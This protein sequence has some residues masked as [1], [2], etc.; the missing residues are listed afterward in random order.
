MKYTDEILI[1]KGNEYKQFAYGNLE[2]GMYIQGVFYEFSRQKLTLEDISIMLPINFSD[3]PLTMAKV[4]YPSEQRPDIIK[5]NVE[6]DI[7]FTFKLLEFPQT[8]QS[9]EQI[10]QYFYQ[11]I[12]KTQ[13][14]NVFYEKNFLPIMGKKLGWFDFKSHAIDCK[15]YNLMYLLPIGRKFLHG[16][17]NC[18]LSEVDLWKPVVL[19]VIHSIED[20]TITEGKG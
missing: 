14:A 3:M 11:V 6:S 7:N 13:P 2:E 20:L 19:Q 5:M 16:I 4:K 1:K 18:P 17:F 12:Q 10:I 15:L 8:E 9:L